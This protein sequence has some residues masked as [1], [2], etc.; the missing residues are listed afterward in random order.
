MSYKVQNEG[1]GVMSVKMGKKH[2][3]YSL[4]H[5]IRERANW[6]KLLETTLSELWKLTKLAATCRKHLFKEKKLLNCGK[7]TDLCDI[8]TFPQSH[9]KF[10]S[11]MAAL[12]N[13]NSH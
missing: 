8:L 3:E 13:Y 9:P 10:S 5:K 12:K 2:S 6:Q 7:N 11:S 1:R 4:L